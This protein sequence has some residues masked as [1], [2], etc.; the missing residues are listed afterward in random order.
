M[1]TRGLVEIAR[2]EREGVIA[3]DGTAGLG[4]RIG[5][6]DSM[7]ARPMRRMY[8]WKVRF[9]LLDMSSLNCL[10]RLKNARSVRMQY[11]A[12]MQPITTGQEVRRK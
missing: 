1:W 2:G 9:L 4:V 7:D 3:Y 11:T 6:L 12:E 5:E 10:R 8:R